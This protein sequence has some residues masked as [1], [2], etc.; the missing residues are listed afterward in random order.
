MIWQPK[1]FKTKILMTHLYME[2]NQFPYYESNKLVTH[3]LKKKNNNCSNFIPKHS[4]LVESLNSKCSCPSSLL[5]ERACDSTEYIHKEW[6]VLC[7]PCSRPLSC[8]GLRQVEL[9]KIKTLEVTSTKYSFTSCLLAHC[10]YLRVKSSSWIET[11]EF[12]P[13]PPFSPISLF[14]RGY[15]ISNAH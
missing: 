13:I 2:Y 6:G 4:S 9:L 10:Q 12:Q 7:P 8:P 15:Q 1:Y 14:H 11:L 3:S 5:W